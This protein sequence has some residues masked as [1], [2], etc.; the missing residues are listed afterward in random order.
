M[1]GIL[2]YRVIGTPYSASS[3][4][5]LRSGLDVGGRGRCENGEDGSMEYCSSELVAEGLEEE[6]EDEEEVEGGAK[7]GLEL[8][9]VVREEAGVRE[10]K[11][12]GE[13]SREECLSGEE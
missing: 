10:A 11:E 9:S 7:E 3:A 12:L 2:S 8:K 13:S 5:T 6:K 4:V 1:I